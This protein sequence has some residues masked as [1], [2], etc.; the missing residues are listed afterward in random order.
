M[1]DQNFTHVEITCIGGIC[2]PYMIPLGDGS[3]NL[4]STFVS[5]LCN[6]HGSTTVSP[7]NHFQSPS[8]PHLGVTWSEFQHS[9][10]F[11]FWVNSD[12]I[13]LDTVSLIIRAEKIHNNGRMAFTHQILSSQMES[14]PVGLPLS[15]SEVHMHTAEQPSTES[16]AGGSSACSCSP[17]L[18][19]GPR[20]WTTHGKFL[21]LA[22]HLASYSHWVIA[23]FFPV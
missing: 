18:L 9:S 2:M 11:W 19:G 10:T 8:P 3:W 7:V 4:I 22:L 23:V 15:Y 6:Y 14:Y 12:L 17:Q 1:V 13:S 21:H 5:F 16:K 20:R